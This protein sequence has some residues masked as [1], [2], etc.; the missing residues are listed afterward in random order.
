[1]DSIL[2]TPLNRLI[3]LVALFISISGNFSLY[4]RL[5]DIYPLNI[6]NLTFLLSLV[7]FFT[8]STILF[9]LLICY[10]NFGRLL[11]ALFLIISSITAYFMDEYGVVIDDVMINNLFET[12]M[13]EVGG[14]IST[15]L[16]IRI[17]V[18]GILPAT[19]VL[20]YKPQISRFKTELKSKLILITLLLLALVVVVIPF[21]SGYA[22]FVREHKLVRYHANP[23]YFIYSL[24]KYLSGSMQSRGPVSIQRV[25]SDLTDIGFGHKKT[26]GILIVGE[27]ARADRFSLNGYTKKTNPELSKQGV[28]SFNNVTSCGTSTGESVPCMFSFLGK[29][30]FDRKKSLSL[31]NVLDVLAE[32]GVKVLWLDNNSNSKGVAD[33]VKYE[34]L[35]SPTRNP[36]CD[37]E[38]RDIGMLDGLE[39]FIDAQPKSDILIVLHQMGNHGPEYYRRYPKAF[40]KFSPICPTGELRECSKEQIDNTYDNAILYTDYFI[41]RTIDFLKKYDGEYETAMLYVSDHGES[42]GERGI[43]LHA[44]PYFMAPQEQIHIPAVLWLGDGFDYE[45]EQVMPYQSYP[46]SHDDLSCLLLIGFEFTTKACDSKKAILEANSFL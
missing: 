34:D 36:I 27:T 40:E 19:L 20:M 22:T 6:S 39:E 37:L 23:T 4:E 11:L 8:I 9:F 21:T 12:D 10:G 29:V 42:L 7:I 41:S 38:C 16:L 26:L 15:G 45:Y 46:L 25:V 31:Q 32:G 17:M 35:K 44:A 30:N 18:L 24:N 3:I 1:M 33:R 2:L 5:I 13:N 14:L 28:I 43:Y